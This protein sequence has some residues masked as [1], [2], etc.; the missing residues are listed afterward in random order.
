MLEQKN[1]ASEFDA[2]VERAFSDFPFF[3]DF[4]LLRVTNG[5][6]APALDCYEKDG[7]YIVDVAIP[8]Y[9]A[10][11]VHVEVSGS[12]VTISGTHKD[13]NEKRS[14]R[15]YQRE[16]RTGSF[17]RSVTLP[18]DL[19][20]ERVEAHLDKGVLTVEL[21]TFKPIAPKKIAVKG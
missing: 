12:T 1:R 10:K 9:E 18:Q 20:P 5:F 7:K 8:G 4:P 2:L 13:S 17:T 14:A 21:T 15:F 6:T 16:L 11:D 3:T 19:D